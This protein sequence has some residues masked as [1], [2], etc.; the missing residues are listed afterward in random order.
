MTDHSP[1]PADPRGRTGSADDRCS[2]CGETAPVSPRLE[3]EPRQWALRDRGWLSLAA[4]TEEPLVERRL[5]C[6]HCLVAPTPKAVELLSASGLSPDAFV[7]LKPPYPKPRREKAQRPTKTLVRKCSSCGR[8]LEKSEAWTIRLGAELRPWTQKLSFK[9]RAVALWY[10]GSRG[11]QEQ[12]KRAA[13]Q[14]RSE[15]EG[16]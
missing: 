16:D 2:S 8:W 3:G 15:G 13:A 1:D 10:C 5:L 7:N 14:H 12:A 6:P 11:C 9:E 4:K